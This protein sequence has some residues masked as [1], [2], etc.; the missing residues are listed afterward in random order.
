[1]F[2]VTLFSERGNEQ[3]PCHMTADESRIADGDDTCESEINFVHNALFHDPHVVRSILESPTEH[4]AIDTEVSHESNRRT[5]SAVTSS[6][7]TLRSAAV[8]QCLFL[9]LN[10]LRCLAERRRRLELRAGTISNDSRAI[11]NLSQSAFAV[12]DEIAILSQPLIRSIAQTCDLGLL[13]VD[14]LV[15]EANVVL[16]RA[17]DLFD[18]SRGFRFSTYATHSVRHHLFRVQRREQR[19]VRRMWSDKNEPA[20]LDCEPEWLD[21]HPGELVNELL[22]E[23]PTRARRFIELRFGLAGR[24][25]GMTLRE[26]ADVARLSDE[27]VRQIISDCCRKA[28][29]KHAARLGY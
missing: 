4:P 18:V 28:R 16:L 1:M 24:D 25:D 11:Y 13:P 29:A 9:K 22:D 20:T 10:C 21:I 6:K 12:R 5:S 27:R 26:I 15:S 8:E 23:M 14:E 2:G 3:D 17:I 19:S 7:T